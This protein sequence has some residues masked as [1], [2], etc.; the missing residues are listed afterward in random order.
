MATTRTTMMGT[1][2]AAAMALD[3]RWCEGG[4]SAEADDVGPALTGTP[5]DS[6]MVNTTLYVLKPAA[7]LVT[8][9]ATEVTVTCEGSETFW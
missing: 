9:W 1:A 3:E 2:M 6:M 4:D 5:V 8:T 7:A